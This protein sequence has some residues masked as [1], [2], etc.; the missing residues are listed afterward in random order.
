MII[1]TLN[2]ENGSNDIVLRNIAQRSTLFKLC[3]VFTKTKP[4]NNNDKSNA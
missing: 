1:L 4:R 3:T 2:Q